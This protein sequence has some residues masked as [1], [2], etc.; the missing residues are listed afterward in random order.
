MASGNFTYEITHMGLTRPSGNTCR[1]SSASIAAASIALASPA[2]AIEDAF[3]NT[4]AQD[5]IIVL[6]LHVWPPATYGCLVPT[7]EQLPYTDLVQRPQQQRSCHR[8]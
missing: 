8:A 4:V 1:L 2:Q 6:S 5:C 7:A 3:S